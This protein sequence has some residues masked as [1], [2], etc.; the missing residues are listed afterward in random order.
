M[1]TCREKLTKNSEK[2]LYSALKP[3]I[4]K[5]KTNINGISAKG[6]KKEFPKISIFGAQNLE[7]LIFPNLTEIF[8]PKKD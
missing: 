8:F 1:I 6:P 4:L 3:K 7:N 2:S 5:I